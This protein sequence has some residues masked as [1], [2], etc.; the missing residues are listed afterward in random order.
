MKKSN[1]RIKYIINKINKILLIILLSILFI[2]SNN[3]LKAEDDINDTQGKYNGEIKVNPIKNSEGYSAILYNNLNGLPTSEA[4]DIVETSDGF[5]WIGSYGGLVKYDG[6]NF[7]R[8]DPST[9]I[10]NVKSLYV[11]SKDRLWIGTN[12][13]GIAY[14]DKN[15]YRLWTKEDG[16]KSSNVR[17]I[18][19]D[20]EGKIYAATTQGLLVFDQD[21]NMSYFNDQKIKNNFINVLHKGKDGTIYGV[22]NSGDV[23]LINNNRVERYYSFHDSQ[24]GGINYLFPDPENS[25]LVYY[26]TL[27]YQLYHGRLE[28]AYLKNDPIDIS[29]LSQIQSMHYI[30]GD[31]WIC[32]R[33]GIG[34][35]DKDGF[36]LL[37]NVPMNF[38]V[39]SMMVDYSGNLWF[40]STRQGVMKIVE[41]R[42]VDV[43]D[44]YHLDNKV[45]NSTCMY[46]DSLFVGTDNGLIVL[47]KDGQVVEEVPIT[48]AVNGRG[49]DLGYSELISTL[50]DAR[51]RSII[52]DSK[53]RIWISTWH[54]FGLI[55]YDAGEFVVFDVDDGLYTDAVRTIVEADDGSIIVAN[56]GGVV[57]FKDDKVIAKY[58]EKEKIT[59][60]EILTVCKGQGDDIIVGTDGAGLF[61]VSDKGTRNLNYEEGLTSG[62]VMR[63]KYD[64]DHHVY[65]LITGDALAYMDENYNITAVKNFPYSNNFDIYENSKG[66]LWV[67]CSNG[68]YVANV[69]DLIKN[70]EIKTV[71]YGISN[72]LSRVATANSYSELT[73]DGDLY[74]AGATG[75]AKTNIE[76]PFESLAD[77]KMAVPY[78]D[79][80][81]KTIY[82]DDNGRFVLPTHFSRL[83]IYG[84]AFAYSLVEPIIKCQLKGIDKLASTGS[85]NE[86]FPLNYF[87]LPG[88]NYSFEMSLMDGLG[89]I[90]KT[91]SVEI[92]KAKAFYEEGWF[93][94]SAILLAGIFIFYFIQKYI[95]S[96]IA[97][98]EK[99]HQE[100]NERKRISDELGMAARI[101]HSMLPHI[102]PP[103]PD[104]KEFDIYASMDPAKGI[105]GDFYDF[106][107]IDD[108]HLCFLIADVSGKGIPGALFMMISKIILQSYAMSGLSVSEILTKSNETICSNNQEGMFVTV[109]IGILEISTGLLKAANAGHEYPVI[110]EPGGKFE[111]YKDKHDF[112]VGGM[113]GLKFHE[114]E[115]TLKKGSKIFLYTDGVPEATDKFNKLFGCE[116][117]V[118]ALNNGLNEKPEDTITTVKDAVNAFVKDAEQFDDLTVLCLKYNGK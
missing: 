37:E 33:N 51:I 26:E 11:D 86:V 114:Y 28:E 74:I 81:G 116:R 18:I 93:Y 66:E 36:H 50:S 57:V 62:T 52:R 38:S 13:N 72:G 44:R 2:F 21:L 4:N 39:G 40:T 101:Q 83:T 113:N 5:I 85:I 47:G 25:E 55:R 70:E 6:I 94:I 63:V 100:E 42:F 45:V 3:S 41:N 34:V 103:F 32:S 22:S 60:T 15:E 112:V 53:N 19:E 35:I 84:R 56:S 9:G 78:V 64:K 108:D 89:N 117:L 27:D 95:D 31:L 75:V 98:I 14:K 111:L 61:I 10:L 23:F 54:R 58:G 92:V 97:A 48:K 82:P 79:I 12:S 49:E 8:I 17:A 104:K 68:I 102:F 90:D 107:M 7:E 65:W 46:N 76:R 24:V 96:R 91:I 69:D 77:I 29:P 105:G 1:N 87:N 71:H 115:L 110:Q 43:F 73:K 20:N 16:I 118:D 30:D 59:N 106:F 80:D 99:K 109:W 67:L 88:G